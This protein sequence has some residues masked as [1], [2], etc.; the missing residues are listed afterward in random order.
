MRLLLILL[1]LISLSACDRASSFD[2]E[3]ALQWSKKA[4]VQLR[5]K[6][7]SFMDQN[8][9][10]RWVSI[11][12]ATMVETASGLMYSGGEILETGFFVYPGDHRVN[13]INEAIQLSKEIEGANYNPSEQ[14]GADQPATAL[15]PKPE[16]NSK[17]K[18]ESEGRSQ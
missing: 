7:A 14:V 1:M 11:S 8:D 15:E 5:Q 10:G 16:G 2:E 18:P 4:D 17:P 6:G 9:E 12:T 3:G 13:T